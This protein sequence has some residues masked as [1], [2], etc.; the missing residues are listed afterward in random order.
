MHLNLLIYSI[1]A[2]SNR[3]MKPELQ[4]NAAAKKV[5]V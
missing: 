1:E 5:V 2:L 3:K 4:R